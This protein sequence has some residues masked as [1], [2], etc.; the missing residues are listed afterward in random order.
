[1]LELGADPGSVGDTPIP[2]VRREMVTGVIWMVGARWVL[3]CIGLIST[4]VLARLL[5]PRDFGLMAMASVVIG[6]LDVL[7]S[8]GVDTALI[9]NAAATR[10]HWDT[11]WTIR[12]IQGAA[13][14]LLLLGLAP[15]A[16]WYY[17]EPRMTTIMPILALGTLATSLENIGTVSFR[18]DL[19]FHRDFQFMVAKKFIQFVIVLGLALIWR[20]YRALMAGIV[21]GAVMSTGLS[22]VLHPFRPKWSL[23][24]APEIWGFSFRLVAI[25]FANYANANGEKLV[26]G[27][28][29]GPQQTGIY[30]VGDEIAATPYTEL[31][32]PIS[33]VTV[34]GFVQIKH[35]R[36]R[37]KAAFLKVFSFVAL[38]SIPA[39]VGLVVVADNLVTVLLGPRWIDAVPVIQLCAIS[40]GC[41]ALYSVWGNLL[42]VLGRLNLLNA[43]TYGHALIFVLLLTP[44]VGH[45]GILGAAGLK[46]MLAFATFVLYAGIGAGAARVSLREMFSVLWRPLVSSLLMVAAC[47]SVGDFFAAPA[48]ALVCKIVV[49]AV[50]YS[51]ACY[52]IWIAS[53]CPDGAERE[54]VEMAS[55]RLR[56]VVASLALLLGYRH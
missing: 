54:L 38:I 50:S 18:K 40:G 44:A 24:K 4:V 25:N 53:G 36:E 2:S 55:E 31:I 29:A 7:F 41:C 37:L 51:V 33:R 49:G 12:G 19:Q 6:F 46:G 56:S 48:A 28:I 17:G 20:D 1:M 43:M 5:L 47:L 13:M 35:D 16:S 14:A 30:Y 26:I 11:A 45:Y 22:F 32:S 8:Q 23:A 21:V 10:A 34:P 42:V 9:Q 3:R 39:S 27:G 52:M 15:L